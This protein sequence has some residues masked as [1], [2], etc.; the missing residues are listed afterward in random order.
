ML[1]Y[2]EVY[3]DEALPKN[4]FPAYATQILNIANQN[5]RGTRPEVVG[6]MSELIKKFNGKNFEDWLAFYSK[7]KPDGIQKAT[8]LLSEMV[9]KIRQML[10]KL[11]E[12]TIELYIRDL[13][14]NKT[15][16]GFKIQNAILSRIARDT[17]QE[18]KPA[19]PED[20]SR[21]IDGYIG[22]LAVS[23]K[24]TSYRNKKSLQEKISGHVIYY[25]KKKSGIHVSYEALF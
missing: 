6:Q 3:S 16:E 12:K 7:Q 5:A 14:L 25:E 13:V 8:K 9:K 23:I 24:P 4:E 19:M 20:E 15:Y 21:G 22:G 1:F 17:K 2:R 10:L 11:D 18:F